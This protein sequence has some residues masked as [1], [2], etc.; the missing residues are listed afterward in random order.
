ML[1]FS[2]VAAAPGANEGQK[3]QPVDAAPKDVSFSGGDGNG[4]DHAIVI[5]G[6]KG[7]RDSVASEMAWLRAHY[8]GYKF[9][10]TTVQTRGKRSFEE[11]AIET[12]AVEKRVV[13]FD[14]TEGFG[15]L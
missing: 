2:V 3:A 13:C 4:C 6:A 15:T 14:V 1:A 7:T 12:A 5:N 8:P 11:V 10:E 9:R